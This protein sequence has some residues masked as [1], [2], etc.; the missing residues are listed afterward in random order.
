MNVREFFRFDDEKGWLSVGL[1]L[2]APLP[3]FGVFFIGFAPPISIVILA[4]KHGVVDEFVP[5]MFF[6]G[7]VLF[8]LHVAFAYLVA[9]A[10][11]LLLS[12]LSLDA[13]MRARSAFGFLLALFILSCFIDWYFLGDLGGGSHRFG[14]FD[15]LLGRI[16]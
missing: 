2:F 15:M 13:P 4:F 7:V 6:I 5:L 14:L 1:S 3:L 12:R 9:C 10:V 11:S 8:L 16:N